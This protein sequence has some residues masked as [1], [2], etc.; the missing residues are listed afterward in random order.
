MLP[1]IADEQAV[2]GRHIGIVAAH[3]DEEMPVARDAAIGRIKADPAARRPAPEHDPGVH[4]V[5]PDQAPRQAKPDTGTAEWVAVAPLADR[6]DG[7]AYPP[8]EAVIEV[9]IKPVA[10]GQPQG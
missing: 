8:V 7:F 6:P 10:I 9:E 2:Y 4:G 3:G 1:G 5:G